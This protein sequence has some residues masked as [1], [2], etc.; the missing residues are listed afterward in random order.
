MSDLERGLPAS[1]QAERT[2]LGAILLERSLCDEAMQ[3]ISPEDFMLD[4]HRRIFRAMGDL[5]ASGAPIDVITITE[6]LIRRKESESVGGPAYISSLID[7]VPHQ[8]SGLEYS[9]IILD[10]SRCRSIVHAS[11][12][13]IAKAQ[14][15]DSADEI[16]GELQAEISN[17][18]GRG[19]KRGTLTLRDVGREWLNELHK[20]RHM[21]GD[22]VI[23][24]T[25]TLTELDGLTT[26]IRESELW[27]IAAR[28]GVGKTA[29][30]R[31]IAIANAYAGKFVVIFTLEMTAKQMISCS[32]AYH[33]QGVVPFYKLRDPRL[34]T[35][36]QYAKV[37]EWTAEVCELPLVFDETGNLNIHQL[38]ARARLHASRGAS[39]FVVDYLQRMKAV[40]AN[41]RTL[42][43]VAQA[44]NA[45]CELAKSTGVPTIALSQLRKLPAGVEDREPSQEDLKETGEIYQ[46]AATVILLH[47][48][49]SEESQAEQMK[50]L[51]RP[52]LLLLPKQRFGDAGTRLDLTFNKSSLS[53]QENFQ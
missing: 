48:P 22:G 49:K 37:Q 43:R 42:E 30:A 12:G 11:N 45:V 4:S 17:Q 19:I 25:T 2:L 14:D 26:G 20:I 47:T 38:A 23:G 21:G 53:F 41:Q 35:E 6:A 36:A 7:G 32:V 40:D 29:F 24:L 33:G 15:G 5:S 34:M 13:A 10:K 28:P 44:S 31:Q 51:H 39:L 46:D 9:K 18:V 50:R 52:A 8:P 3:L 27:V 16:L 1:V